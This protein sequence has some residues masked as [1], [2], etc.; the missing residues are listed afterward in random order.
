MT[1]KIIIK[2]LF[3]VIF[4]FKCNIHEKN[5]FEMKIIIILYFQT[6]FQLFLMTIFVQLKM[7]FFWSGFVIK[8][9][10]KI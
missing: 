3:C 9:L 1:L 6:I 7:Q 5:M 8:I 10:M 2:Y 4:R